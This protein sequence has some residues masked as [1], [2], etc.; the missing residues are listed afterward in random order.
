MHS[1]PIITSDPIEQRPEILELIPIPERS[2]SFTD[3][4]NIAPFSIFT[5]L[6]QLSRI[7]LPHIALNLRCPRL[8]LAYDSGIQRPKKYRIRPILRLILFI[9]NLLIIY[10]YFRNPLTRMTVTIRI[11]RMAHSLIGFFVSQQAFELAID[12]FF[13]CADQL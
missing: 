6:P 1:G 10:E 8:I 7:N 3:E 5:S 13:I 11:R 2:P 12:Y 9:I 4:E